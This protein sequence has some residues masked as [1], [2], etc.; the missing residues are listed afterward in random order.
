MYVDLVVSKVS[1]A[2][3]RA[4]SIRDQRRFTITEMTAD[5]LGNYTHPALA[6]IVVRGASWDIPQPQQPHG[7]GP[8]AHATPNYARFPVTLR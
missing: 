5:W 2:W 4:L 3:L 7:R 1:D 8:I 6:D